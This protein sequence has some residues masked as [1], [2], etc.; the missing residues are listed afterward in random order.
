MVKTTE[1]NL[2]I[3]NWHHWQNQTSESVA[4]ML[5]LHLTTQVWITFRSHGSYLYIAAFGSSSSWER[6][7][8]D[9]LAVMTLFSA[10]SLPHH[11]K[12]SHDVAW[13]PLKIKHVFHHIAKKKTS[14]LIYMYIFT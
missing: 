6:W 9:L 1:R 12:I 2:K 4:M 14:E 7:K 13:Q 11:A 5:A 3:V 8:I 10:L